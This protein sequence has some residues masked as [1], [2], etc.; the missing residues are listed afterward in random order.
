MSAREPLVS[1]VLPVLDG[2]DTLPAV[3]ASVLAQTHGRLELLIADNA[4]T[5]GTPEICRALAR[6]DRRV[7][8]LRRPE[9][10]GLLANFTTAADAA[11]GDFIRWIGDDDALEPTYLERALEAFAEDQRRVLVTT[12]I[13]YVDADGTETLDTSHDP[14]PLSSPDPVERFAE[15]LRLLNA[16]FAVLDPA[17]GLMRREVATMPRRNMLRE[18]QVFAGRLALAGPWGHVAAPLARRPRSESTA[19]HLARMLGVPPWRRHVRAVL[20]CRELAHWIASAPLTPEQR[21]RAYAEVLRLY[22]EGKRVKL[23]R[24]VA[25]LGQVRQAAPA[26]LRVGRS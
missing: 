10:I 17:Y 11:T 14:R 9:R 16:G 26:P 8:H 7:V 5:D 3:V 24:G 13:V 22:A 15:M 21:R 12:Q 23:G 4:S 1:V 6:E 19:E 25:K 20:Q 18:D 2:A